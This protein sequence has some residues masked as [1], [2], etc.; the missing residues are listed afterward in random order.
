MLEVTHPPSS[1]AVL[2]D[3]KKQPVAYGAQNSAVYCSGRS[4]RPGR[5]LYFQQ[6]QAERESLRI[7]SVTL[8]AWTNLACTIPRNERSGL[9]GER[10]YLPFFPRSVS[11]YGDKKFPSFLCKNRGWFF[12]SGCARTRRLW[13]M[14]ASIPTLVTNMVFHRI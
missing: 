2:E 14:A 5:L 9:I 3:V 1:F 11:I 4:R 13:R 6:D 10:E 8:F 7:S 12:C